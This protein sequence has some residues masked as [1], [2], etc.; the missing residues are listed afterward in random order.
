MRLCIKINVTMWSYAEYICAYFVTLDI[1][2]A[3]DTPNK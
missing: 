3:A 2:V 1:P